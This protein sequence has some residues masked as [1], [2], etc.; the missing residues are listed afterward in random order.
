MQLALGSTFGVIT[1]TN[2]RRHA[3]LAGAV[4]A[5]YY[6]GSLLGFALR[7]PPTGISFLWPPTAILSAILL[8]I[9]PRS[10]PIAIAGA[11]RLIRRPFNRRPSGIY[12]AGAIR[13]Q[14]PAG[15]AGGVGRAFDL[16]GPC[17]VRK[18]SERHRV[19]RRACPRRPRGG[20]PRRGTGLRQH[21]LVAD[22]L[23]GV[24][25]QG[26]LERAGGADLRAAAG[27]PDRAVAADQGSPHRTAGVRLACAGL[28]CA[29]FIAWSAAEYAVS[30]GR[31]LPAAS[32]WRTD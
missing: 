9:S 28:S 12:L 17:A 27:R 24:A 18:F 31:S 3:L 7:L 15:N 26:A 21:G 20:V 22:V 16:R 23:G 14:L 6:F 30:A 10:W 1:S 5:A 25:S 4:A 32:A 29:L 2:L 19:R 11:F 13:R 8:S